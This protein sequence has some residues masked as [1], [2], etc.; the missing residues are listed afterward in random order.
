MPN[1]WLLQTPQ[2]H[3]WVGLVALLVLGYAISIHREAKR[4]TKLLRFL[5]RT[6]WK[7]MPDEKKRSILAQASADFDSRTYARS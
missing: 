6:A 2:Y 7:D 4:H 5:C 1:F 3:F